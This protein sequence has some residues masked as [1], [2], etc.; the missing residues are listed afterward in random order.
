MVESAELMIG[1]GVLWGASLI[2]FLLLI[3]AGIY[4]VEAIRRRYGSRWVDA[5]AAVVII[6]LAALAMRYG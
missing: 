2:L 1:K 3:A 4:A 5:L 6:V